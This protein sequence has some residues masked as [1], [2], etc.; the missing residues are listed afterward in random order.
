MKKLR[1]SCDSSHSVSE[2]NLIQPLHHGQLQRGFLRST[3]ASG[4]SLPGSSVFSAG[5]KVSALP[6]GKPAGKPRAGSGPHVHAALTSQQLRVKTARAQRARGLLQ[7]HHRT[8]PRT[9]PRTLHPR[10]AK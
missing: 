7:K 9:L 3:A 6:G 4:L 10:G 2:G 1:A 5:G 8:L